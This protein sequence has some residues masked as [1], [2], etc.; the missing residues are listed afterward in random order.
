[1]LRIDEYTPADW[2]EVWAILEPVIRAGETYPCPPDMNEAEARRFWVDTTR[3]VFVA[4][5]D[6]DAMVGAFYIK[7]DQIGLGDHVANCGY[8]VAEAARGRG[9]AVEMCLASQRLAKE[10]GFLAMKF[11]LV[12]ATNEAAVKAWTKC[13]MRILTTIPKAFRHKRLGLVDA[14]IMFRAL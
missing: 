14:H 3:H 7:P 8:A 9:L 1:M 5:N 2:P 10:R 6:Q 13:G 12:V 11:N 4:R